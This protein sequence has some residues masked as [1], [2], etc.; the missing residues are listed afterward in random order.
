MYHWM[1][2]NGLKAQRGHAEEIM[3]AETVLKVSIFAKNHHFTFWRFL[4][5]RHEISKIKK[6]CPEVY[7]LATC[8]PIFSLIGIFLKK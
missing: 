8:M 1:R 6:K 4:S 5:D 7:Y 2:E 3:A